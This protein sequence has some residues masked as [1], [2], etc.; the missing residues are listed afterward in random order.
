M[1]KK[2]QKG[3]LSLPGSAPKVENAAD[4]ISIIDSDG[5]DIVKNADFSGATWEQATAPVRDTEV[6]LAEAAAHFG[7]TADELRARVEAGPVEEISADDLDLD[8]LGETEAITTESQEAPTTNPR[9]NPQDDF[10]ERLTLAYVAARK[11]GFGPAAMMV[12]AEVERPF[13]KAALDAV[14]T[15]RIP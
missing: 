14:M 5:N 7:I 3:R 15:P 2:Y 4:D 6:I 11:K 1:S 9:T 10:A 13:I 12:R 8:G